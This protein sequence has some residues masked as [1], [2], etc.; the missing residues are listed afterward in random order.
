[1][2]LRIVREL[3]RVS[4]AQRCSLSGAVERLEV[5]LFVV[6]MMANGVDGAISA[7]RDR[8]ADVAG[9]A[10]RGAHVTVADMLLADFFATGRAS[11][12]AVTDVLLGVQFPF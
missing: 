6:P 3:L 4:P 12:A 9:R 5:L 8:L 11:A 2:A 10:T 7:L 1:M